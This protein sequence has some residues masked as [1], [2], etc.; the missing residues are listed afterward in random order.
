M[1]RRFVAGAALAA[2][3][4]AGA[5]SAAPI[6]PIDTFEEGTTQGWTVALGPAGGVHPAPPQ[7]VATGGPAG[8]DDSFLRLT[9]VGG[10]G[11][12]SRLAAMNVLQWTGDYLAEG[13]TGIRMDLRNAGN[14]DLAVRLLFETLPP[15]G[16]PVNVAVTNFAAI[17]PA[18]GEWQSVFFPLGPDALT[19]LLGSV[20][21]AL[22]QTSVL[23]IFHSPT[24]DFPPPPIAAVLDVDNIAVVQQVPEPAT[25]LLVGAALIACRLRRSC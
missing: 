10:Q 4:V 14:S 19:A 5:A 18:G 8:A 22:A 9:S 17:L 25:L 1:L 15:L 13:V 7:N 24:P 21:G 20:G 16:P 12:G 6:G 2:V 23:R 3:S 11:A